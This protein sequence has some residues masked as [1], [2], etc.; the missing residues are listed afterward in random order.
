MGHTKIVQIIIERI[1]ARLNERD[2]GERD[3][4]DSH[5]L[6]DFK[7]TEQKERSECS[8]GD[9]NPG[10]SFFDLELRHG[11]N[12]STYKIEWDVDLRGGRKGRACQRWNQ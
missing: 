12:T 8:T 6:T 9:G 4:K 3:K 7:E 11:F 10:E 1:F 2:S 5:F